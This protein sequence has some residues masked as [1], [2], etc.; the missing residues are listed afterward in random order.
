MVFVFQI[1]VWESECW[2]WVAGQGKL[3]VIGSKEVASSVELWHCGTVP[4]GEG[5]SLGRIPGGDRLMLG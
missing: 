5:I 2:L 1:E 3:S 4:S